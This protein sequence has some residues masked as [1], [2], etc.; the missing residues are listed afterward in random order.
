MTL[1]QDKEYLVKEFKISPSLET[2]SSLAGLLN[3]VAPYATRIM[4]SRGKIEADEFD[5]LSPTD[6]KL[7]TDGL[8]TNN[9]YGFD[10]EDYRKFKA[11]QA[12]TYTASLRAVTNGGVNIYMDYPSTLDREASIFERRRGGP[13]R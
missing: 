8:V 2:F 12:E 6:F 9:N 4:I 7:Y 3:F 10:E 1:E 5:N 13:G 11:D